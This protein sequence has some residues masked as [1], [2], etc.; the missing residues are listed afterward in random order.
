[1]APAA[2]QD[3]G[4]GGTKSSMTTDLECPFGVLGSQLSE[5]DL[6]ETAYEIFIAACRPS[7]GRSS[8]TYIPQ[9]DK[10]E[11]PEKSSPSS[12]ASSL[13]PSIQKSLTSTAASRVKRA[14]GLRSS[15]KSSHLKD[16][17]PSRSR[18]PQTIG[19]L[20]RLQMNVSE[21][22]DA[23]VRRALLRISAGQLGK[24]VESIVLPL[25]LLQQFK[26]S[27]FSDTQEYQV[28][29]RR[30]L[31]ILEAGL[32]LHPAVPLERSDAAAQRLRQIVR[33]AE[34]KPI[35]TGR[36]SEAMQ[37]LRSA[38]MSLAW[39]ST[40]GSTPET[41]HWADGFPLNL[42]LYQMLLRAC[43][44]SGEETAVIDEIDELM[45]MMKKTWALLGINQMLH[46]ICFTWVIFQQFLMTGQIDTDLL[47][48]AENQLVEVAKDA[49]TVKDPLYVKVLSSTL[50]AIQGW[51]EKRLLAYHE[52]FQ[53]TSVGFME[54]VISVAVA[55]AKVLVDDISHEYRRKRK[56][57]VDVARN[58]IDMYI[59]SSLRTAFAQM[60]EQVDSRRRSFKKQQNPPP[61]LTVL[62]NDI[63]DLAR[64]EKEKFS[65]ILKR[66]HPFA[67]GV[68]VATLHACYGREL[69]QFLS[70]VI[71]LTLE[72]VQVLEAADKLEKDLVQIAVEDSVDCED[73][74]K[75]VIREMPPYEVDSILADLSRTWIK[76]RLERLR[77]WVDRS[78]QQEDWTPVANKEKYAP[79]AVEVLRIVEET[80]DAFF[81]LPLSQHSDLLPDLVAGLERALQ[82]Y[83]S[84][85]KSGCG[86]KNSYV[87]LLP[88]LTR[89]ST[90]SKFWKKKEKSSS[91]Q[92]RKSQI[93]SMNSSE[94]MTLSQL[95]VRINTLHRIRTETEQLEKRI[96]YGWKMDL[97]AKDNEKSKVSLAPI[98]S[99]PE[100]K[101][102]LSQA[103]SKEG[104]QQLCECTAY[105]VVFHDLSVVLWDGLYLGGTA[106]ARIG[107]FLEQLESNL[108]IIAD[109]VH[110]RVRTRVLTALMK[111]CFDG[112]LLVLLG[113]G[114]SR[115][116]SKS[117]SEIIEEDFVALKNLFKADGDGLPGE[118]V[119][120]AAMPVTDIF[121]LFST[122]TEGLI[123]NFRFA[124]CQ[125]NGLSSTKSKLPLP[126]TTGVWS[127]TEPNTLLR[128]LCYRNDEAATK[129]LKKTYG[130][131][132]RL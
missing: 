62:A 66:W 114:P 3:R 127:P 11:R 88:A 99:A 61:A 90:G 29:Q 89:C 25:E 6:R 7:A 104:I 34:E 36:N 64:N 51:A 8:L 17:S 116:F 70:G 55:A 102:E 23:R 122:N 31:L 5:D 97:F 115:A 113:G 118:L 46:N 69:K 78:L 12:S 117:D 129:F 59:R 93:V 33:G 9:S 28:W 1:M 19:E 107:P 123:E 65:P 80:L 40:D 2:V 128:V 119:E 35:E 91:H 68:A 53:S 16:G 79:S 84:Q 85:T 111:A 32:L 95:C 132:K 75:G 92:K 103:G 131:P 24:R 49:K 60:M 20:L 83:I 4:F 47:G 130:L 30:N 72:S 86:S 45:E 52:T 105:K 81:E 54:S 26:S 98:G 67:A 13:S 125:A 42:W 38:V 41:C 10:V 50:S 126:P 101:F 74:G 15:K 121:P 48:A 56:E 106:G 73:G 58:R 21:Q 112:F 110:T 76:E 37:A 44:D 87:P 39:R 22:T 18:R 63:G 71:A 96:S 120:K 27:D 82:R 108:E 57:E 109:T 14:L 94:P 77:E 124:V 43:F 100:A